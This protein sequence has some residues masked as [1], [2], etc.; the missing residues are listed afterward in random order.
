MWSGNSESTLKKKK[1]YFS[2]ITSILYWTVRHE[3]EAEPE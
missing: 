3:A 1:K 2:S